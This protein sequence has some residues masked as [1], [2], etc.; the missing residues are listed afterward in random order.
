MSTIYK[1]IAA[2]LLSLGTHEMIKEVGVELT[3]LV[4]FIGFLLLLSN[5]TTDGCDV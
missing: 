4:L 3:I 1:I 5:D 2:I